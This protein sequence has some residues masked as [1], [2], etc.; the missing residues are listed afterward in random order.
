MALF[1]EGTGKVIDTNDTSLAEGEFVVMA[2]NIPAQTIDHVN[3]QQ[4]KYPSRV[5]PENHAQDNLFVGSDMD[6]MG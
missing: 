2:P 1:H 3:H 6:G 5:I 4:S